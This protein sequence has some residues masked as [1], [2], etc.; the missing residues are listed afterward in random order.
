MGS[1]Y[2]NMTR[3]R[4]RMALLPLTLVVIVL[5]MYMNTKSWIKTGI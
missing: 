2:E 4:E 3:V 5:L 1:Q